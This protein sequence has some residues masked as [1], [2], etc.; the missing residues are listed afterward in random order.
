MELGYIRWD[1]SPEL[2]S[3]GPLTIRW[4]GLL[5]ALG[6][7]IGFKLMTKIFEHEKKSIEDLNQLFYHVIIGTIVGARLGHCLFY[8]PAY[9]LSNPLEILKIWHGGLASHGGV[10][11]IVAAVYLYSRQHPGQDLIWVLDRLTIPA[12][13]GATFIRLGNLFN[14]EIL[15]NPTDVPWAII[16]VRI[17]MLPRHPAQLY[18]AITY[19][20]IFLFLLYA[21][22]KLALQKQR[23]LLLG[24]LL[25]S[26]F[27]A[28]FLI[29]FVKERQESFV[30][31][32]PVNVGQLLSIPAVLIGIYLIIRSLNAPAV[33]AK[34]K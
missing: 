22:W 13:L 12:M 34:S 33:P 18:E 23:G 20:L 27:S 2:F 10:M 16:F 30:L 8:D 11:G 26:V 5:F 21:Y 31:G 1:V 4:Y 14:S 29:E 28:R 17:D 25:T 9:Y 24:I 3:L 15:G 7:L 32:L 19:A 6:F